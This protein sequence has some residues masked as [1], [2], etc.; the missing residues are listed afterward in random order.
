MIV[1]SFLSVSLY[2]LIY[3]ETPI[4]RFIEGINVGCGAYWIV[5]RIMRYWEWGVVRMFE[6]GEGHYVIPVILG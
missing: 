5:F 1:A 4:T 3:G 2:M 6:P